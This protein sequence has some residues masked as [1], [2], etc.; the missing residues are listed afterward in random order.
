MDSRLSVPGDGC[1]S[2][3]KSNLMD[4]LRFTDE[5]LTRQM[6]S[7]MDVDTTL[8]HFA[9]V[10]YMVAPDALRSH[11]HS[12]F[13]LDIVNQDYPD[14]ALVSVVPFVDQDFR[15]SRFPWFK[16]RFA[17][18]NYRTY[19]TDTETGEHVAWFFGTSL[20]SFAVC[21][22]RHLWKLPWHRADIRFDCN[23][24]SCLGRYLSY[25]MEARNSWADAFLELEDTG[26]TPKI[27]K[28]FDDLET[29]LVLLTHPRRGYFYRRDGKLGSYSIWHD[30]LQTTVGRVV[31]ARFDLLDS[32]GLVN[33][34]DISSVHS[35]LVQHQ[36]EFTI[37]LPPVTV[38][39]IGDSKRDR[40]NI[41]VLG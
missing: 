22:P 32:L 39:S 27:L 24:D 20:D 19:V 16:R 5:L 30:R 18:T 9:I 3:T 34:G 14:T 40:S 26:T 37:Y 8:S 36:T 15:F 31:D 6:P 1:R 10:T 25:R 28:G 13:E 12:R 4:T 35:V 29:G 7:G 2:T 21:V 11:V 41:E 33:R 38:T 23:Y 17:Q